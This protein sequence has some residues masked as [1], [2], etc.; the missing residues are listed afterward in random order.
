MM[1]ARGLLRA[2]Q[3]A[4]LNANYMAHRLQSHYPIL[5]RGDKGVVAHEFIVDLRPLKKTSGIEPVDVAKRLM[6]FGKFFLMFLEL[7]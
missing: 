4:I 6:D 3:I 7:I 5:H 2:T 1:G